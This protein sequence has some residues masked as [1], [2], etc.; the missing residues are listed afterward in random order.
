MEELTGRI[1][2]LEERVTFAVKESSERHDRFVAYHA[3][4][5]ADVLKITSETKSDCKEQIRDLFEGARFADY[6]GARDPAGD[7]ERPGNYELVMGTP[8]RVLLLSQFKFFLLLIPTMIAVS[9]ATFS[10]IEEKQSRSL[11]PLLATP[12]KTREVLLGKALGTS[13]Q[14]WLNLQN[15]WDLSQ[16]DLRASRAIRPLRI[17]A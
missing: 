1:I 16:V 7:V 13:A 8:F 2:L 10:I 4:N 14:L 11:E 12:V 5:V 9:F 15:N 3:K 6:A 17:P